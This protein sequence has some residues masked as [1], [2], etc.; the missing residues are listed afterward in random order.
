MPF[1]TEIVTFTA[2]EAYMADV[3]AIYPAMRKV[4]EAEG[5]IRYVILIRLAR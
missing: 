5:A 4:L 3:A 1:V 2:S